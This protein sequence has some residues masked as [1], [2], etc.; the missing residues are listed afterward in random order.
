MYT[1]PICSYMYSWSNSRL[2]RAIEI[3][4]KRIYYITMYVQLSSYVHYP[5]LR[6]TCVCVCV[7]IIRHDTIWDSNDVKSRVNELEERG[8]HSEWEKVGKWGEKKQTIRNVI[9]M[10][11]L[12]HTWTRYLMSVL[13]AIICVRLNYQCCV[14]VCI[15]VW[16]N[17]WYVYVVCITVD[18]TRWP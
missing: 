10:C 13:Y 17:S 9:S 3:I 16:I 1:Y 4:D 2:D 6:T 5:L 12:T 15:W 8:C 11:V 18:S 14:C 7:C